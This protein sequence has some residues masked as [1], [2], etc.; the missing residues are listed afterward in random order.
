M[1]RAGAW[2][3]RYGPAELTALAGALAGYVLIEVATG[4]RAAAAFGA[5]AGDNVGYYGLLLAREI[6]LRQSVRRA[7]RE[8]ALEFGPAE[9]VDGTIVRPACTALAAGLLGPAG[10]LAAKLMADV[11]FYAPV[12]ATYELRRSRQPTC[13]SAPAARNVVS[14]PRDR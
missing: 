4:N 5:A 7:L 11:V 10:V 14:R 8:L 9:A 6:T 12:I 1:A 13:P 3:R 2:L